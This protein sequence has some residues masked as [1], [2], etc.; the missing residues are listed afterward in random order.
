MSTFSLTLLKD[1]SI[2][3]IIGVLDLSHQT[4]AAARSTGASL[5]AYSTSALYYLV[6]SVAVGFAARALTRNLEKKV[7]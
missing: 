1:S 5:L 2:P 3:S 6:L 7:R 4:T